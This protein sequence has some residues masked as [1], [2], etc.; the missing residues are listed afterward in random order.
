MDVG[1]Q[2]VQRIAE[3]CCAL[4]QLQQK[5]EHCFSFVEQPFTAMSICQYHKSC[6]RV[7]RC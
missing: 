1:G 5:V 3:V 6:E 2:T 4:S 7:E